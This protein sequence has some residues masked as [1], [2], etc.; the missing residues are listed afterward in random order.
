MGSL[1]F[2]YT[3]DKISK[4]ISHIQI[5]IHGIRKPQIQKFQPP[6]YSDNGRSICTYANVK[7]NYCGKSGK[8]K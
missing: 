7:S 6:D 8:Y 3:K 4:K 5:R 1:V 2:N